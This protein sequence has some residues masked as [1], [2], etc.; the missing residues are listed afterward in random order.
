M[1]TYVIEA[2]KSGP[3]MPLHVWFNNSE[4]KNLIDSFIRKNLSLIS[5]FVSPRLANT[6]KNNSA[7]LYSG[8][9]MPVFAVLAFLIWAKQ[10]I[11]KE[12]RDS[13]VTFTEMLRCG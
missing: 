9:A 12:K 6:V 11:E 10:N 13:S 8:R 7:V 5:E 3:T 4:R 2:K 1:P